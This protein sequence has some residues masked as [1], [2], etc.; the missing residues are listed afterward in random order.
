M[1][2]EITGYLTKAW[3]LVIHHRLI[4]VLSFIS[5][6]LSQSPLLSTGTDSH[7]QTTTET[8]VY[9]FLSLILL[10]AVIFSVALMAA[11]LIAIDHIRVNAPITFG[12]ARRAGQTHIWDLI[13][14]FLLAVLVVAIP[15]IIV[16]VIL[17]KQ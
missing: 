15:V 13:G 7:N 14:F 16:Y 1:L 11:L 3:Q 10:A 12:E 17:G 8:A 5:L 9:C 6:L 2:Q 4:W